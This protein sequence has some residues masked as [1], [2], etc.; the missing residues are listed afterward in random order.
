MDGSVHCWMD[1]RKNGR[2][3][4]KRMDGTKRARMVRWKEG[5]MNRWKDGRR[6]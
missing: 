3:K 6:K 5:W 1:G 2:R 4:E